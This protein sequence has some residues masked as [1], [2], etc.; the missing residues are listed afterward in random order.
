MKEKKNWQGLRSLL[1][2]LLALVLALTPVLSSLPAIEA[3]AAG[4]ESWYHVESGSGN[5]NG[6]TYSNASTSP[7]AV[8]LNQSKKMPVDGSFSVTY[9]KQGTPSD[10]RFGVFYLYLDDGNWLYVGCNPS[11]KWYYE[12]K[13]NGGENSWPDLNDLDLNSDDSV[14]DFTVSLSRESLSVQVGDSSQIVSNQALATLAEKANG[15]GRFG[16]RAGTYSGQYTSFHFTNAKLG[17]ESLAGTE[18]AFLADCEGQVLEEEAPIPKY[19]VSGTVQNSK[20]EAVA[21]AIV[22]VGSASAQTGADGSFVVEDIEEGTYSLSVSAKGYAPYSQSV[23][24]NSDLAVGTITLQE[25]ADVVYDHYIESADIKAAVS[26]SFPQVMQYVVKTGD[27]A[28]K[29]VLG[30]ET[31]LSTIK[32]NNTSIAPTVTN[33]AIEADHAVYQMELKNTAASI[34]L[35]MDVKISVKE[36]DL[37]WE[38][39][40]L[41][42]NAGCAKIHTIEVPDLNLVT[43]TDDLSDAQFK[44]ANVSTATTVSGDEEIT[45]EKGFR[46][47]TTS[48]YTYG[49]VS[50]D[51][52]SAGVWSNSEASNDK[53]VIRNNG[54]NS[55][56]LTSAHWYSEYGDL[57]ASAQYDGTPVSE[58]PCAKVCLAGDENEDGTVD[59]QDGA[60]AY[61]D[62]MN[63]PYGSENTKNLVNYRIVMNFSSQATNPYLKTADNIKK[64]Y[65]ATDGLPQ[66]IMM[67]GYGSEGH[68]SANSEYGNIA[69]RL[70]G[71]EELKKLNSIAHQYNTQTG[72]HINAT[73]A[74]PEAQSFSDELIQ[75]PN[76]P[77]WDW[78]DQAYLIDIPYDTGSG[79]RYKRLLQLYDQLNDTS[80]YANAWPGVV[81]EG[82]DETVADSETIARTVAEKKQTVDTNLDFMYLDVWYGNSWV[83]RKIAQEINSLGWRFSTEFGEEGEYDSTWQ[84]WATEG[85]YGGASKKGMNSEVMRFLRNHQKDSYVLNWPSYGGTADNPLL[86][87]FDLAGFE[88]WGNNNN[89][90]EYITKTFA[91]NLPTKF[92]QHYLV[93][94][95][96][97]YENG[98][99]PVGNQEKQI[100]LKNGDDIVVVTRNEQQRTDNYVERTITLND[101]VILDDVTYLL[102]WIDSETNEE[103]LYHY[104]YDGG[105][106]EWELQDDWSSLASVVVYKLTDAGRIEEQTVPVQ[107]GKI[108]LTAEAKTPYVVLKGKE[109]AKTVTDFGD[110]SHV[111]D[112]G[113]NSYAGTG[114]GN[115]L[116]SKVWTGD[117]ADT[118]VVRV[119]SG[120]KYLQMGKAD[121]ETKVSTTISDL[122]AGKNYVA[123]VYVD[124][125]SD[126]KAW[127]EVTGGEKA[128]SNYTLKSL[129]GNYVRCDAHNV[130]AVSNSKMQVMLVSFTA[131]TDKAT[132]TLKR[133]AGE[134]ITYFD[135]IRI[136]DKTLHNEQAD[137]SFVQDFETVVGGIYPFVIGPAQGVDDQ[138]THL[139]EKHAPYTQSGWGNVVIDDVLDGKW[140]LKHHASNNGIIYRT[141]PQNL[142]LEPNVTYEISF[143]YQAGCANSYRM[144]VGDGDDTI[145]TLEYLDKTAVG[146]GQ[147]SVTKHYTFQVTGSESG[148]SWFGLSSTGAT[149]N[150][151]YGKR[152][153]VLD[154]L[155]VKKAKMSLSKGSLELH[156]R[157][158]SEKLTASFVDG[159]S[160]E[161][162]WS[163]SD[164]SIVVVDAEGNVKAT[165][166]GEAVITASAD[167]DGETVEII[168]NVKVIEE[169]IT[170]VEGAFRSVIANTEEVNGENAPASCIIDGNTSTFWHSEWQDNRFTVSETNPAIATLTMKDETEV[171]DG[172]YVYQR[173]SGTNGV[174]QKFAYSI[175]NSYDAA[176]QTVGDVTAEGTIT[177][178]G[179]SA[180][181]YADVRLETPVSGKYLQIRVLAGYNSYAAIGEIKTYTVISYKGEQLVYE[182]QEELA[183]AQNTLTAAETQVSEAN[184]AV[185]AAKADAAKAV[186]EKEKAEADVKVAEAEAKA[187]EAALAKTQAQQKVYE[188]EAAL[189]TAEA[190]I[191]EDEAAAEQKRQEAE[192]AQNNAEAMNSAI[193]EQQSKLEAAQKTLEAA[194]KKLDDLSA[195]EEAKKTLS[196]KVAAAKSYAAKDYTAASY[197]GLQKAI[198]AAETVLADKNAVKVQVEKAAAD[199]DKAIAGLVK[200]S[201]VV[202]K[203]GD[204]VTDKK[205]ITYKVINASKKTV[206]VVKYSKKSAK[207]VIIPATVK[208]KGVTCKVVQIGKNVFKSSKMK[209]VTVGKYVTSIGKSA[210]YNCT[211]LKKVTFKGPAVK[212]IGKNAF[213]KTAS[214]ITVKV[215]KSMKKSQ[216]SKF[217]SKLTKAGMSKKLKLK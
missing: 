48:G 119:R 6:H 51:G 133:E 152:D 115:V 120:N 173:P 195:V 149:E 182:K 141:I 47:N 88:G 83:T 23:E 76:A 84:H 139:S 95:W 206:A 9:Q 209:S 143:D 43:I 214:K 186:T 127:I 179:G 167:I 27:A 39:T 66:A 63:N 136:V 216:R 25:R 134:G 104:N 156:G 92:L 46:A 62:I 93:Y 150:N 157:G 31:E 207:T 1:A 153:F 12:Y 118:K 3:Q 154:N 28:G 24:V 128:V 7:A 164:D 181:T 193:E 60:I 137:G 106:T 183:N 35:N 123:Q 29:T 131:K 194:Q 32:I 52:V 111:A 75:G 169:K 101:K 85:S 82:E 168:C 196:Q 57:A 126:A 73:E 44:G 10:A 158:D 45:F 189:A 61:R 74:Y 22:R 68:D 33:V 140:S 121:A 102:P 90:D 163:S 202:L 125:K 138:R 13:V 26:E 112:P 132:L 97:D 155:V 122:T 21:D 17:T 110:A 201:P 180:G 203:K 192:Q 53:R 71:V 87:G 65:L 135:D 170:V 200:V 14:V 5:G 11:G 217:K 54:A 99:S 171:F 185:D 198:T 177:V 190:A 19:S 40:K 188:A 18:W 41:Q 107:G 162:T 91:I 67:K 208:V 145:Q 129:A 89:F 4:E 161:V 151:N 15:Q 58:L 55:I 160:R 130:N 49:F 37:I 105:T 197:A 114:D 2:G 215:P 210:F 100:T 165:G 117:T 86:G 8:L 69:E 116:D 42:K 199:L 211:K 72:I 108:T 213:K 178:N 20:G 30:Q 78:L 146:V 175:G 36:N 176:T 124:N 34:D 144:V 80:L 98:E 81:G 191:A 212:T 50:A 148:Q 113:F 147:K 38:V 59:W 166:L 70:G 96:E 172:F 184:S 187:A 16:F 142:H 174:L 64:V 56:A 204:K 159:E 77:N 79:L 109:A 94:K 103:K 205:G